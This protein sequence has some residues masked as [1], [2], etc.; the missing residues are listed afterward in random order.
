VRS[1][2]L[3]APDGCTLSAE[4]LAEQLGRAARLAPAVV[5]VA[6]SETGIRVAFASG[7]DDALVGELIATEQ[8]CCSFLDLRY[9]ERV[10]KIES[11]DPRGPEV[12]NRLAAYFGEGR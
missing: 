10:L 11:S 9:G 5:D 6:R 3:I 7:V 12:I 2:P 1:L 8:T 4:G